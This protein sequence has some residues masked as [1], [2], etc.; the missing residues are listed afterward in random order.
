MS[1]LEEIEPACQHDV[2]DR[3]RLPNGERPVHVSYE[4]ALLPAYAGK[5]DWQFGAAGFIGV[6]VKTFGVVPENVK[7]H[8]SG[9]QGEV[10]RAFGNAIMSALL[11]STK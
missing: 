5:R 7:A 10:L 1:E 2:A 11:C 3:L 8:G 9:S 6:S 4:A